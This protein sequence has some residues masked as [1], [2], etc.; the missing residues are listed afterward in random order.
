M[1]IQGCAAYCCICRNKWMTS[2]LDSVT[3]P[4]PKQQRLPSCSEL[5]CKMHPWNKLTKHELIISIRSEYNPVQLFGYLIP[6][7]L[8]CPPPPPLPT[9][10]ICMVPAE[11][12]LSN[13]G[14]VTIQIWEHGQSGAPAGAAAAPLLPRIERN[15]HARCSFS[16]ALMIFIISW[17]VVEV[18]RWSRPRRGECD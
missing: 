5:K 3:V 9:C 8:H 13:S 16:R 15:I 7:F 17:R 4:P 12:Q 10:I 1:I 14:D 18:S 11:P 6:Q 2:F